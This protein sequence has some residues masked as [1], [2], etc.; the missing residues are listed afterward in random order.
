MEG[1]ISMEIKML[2]VAPL[3]TNCYLVCDETEKVCA[4]W[5]PAEMLSALPLL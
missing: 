1:E 3:G 4:G 2:Q 5:I